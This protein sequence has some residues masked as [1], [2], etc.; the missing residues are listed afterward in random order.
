MKMPY[1]KFISFLHTDMTQV[2][3]IFPHVR[4]EITLLHSKFHGCWGRGKAKIQ[5]INNH[6]IDFVEPEYF[7]PH[8]LR[9]SVFTNTSCMVRIALSNSFAP[10]ICGRDFKYIIFTLLTYNSFGTHSE[11]ASDW[12]SQNLTNEKSTWIHVMVWWRQA[13]SHYLSQCWP[14]SMS[15]YGIAKPQYV[16]AF[17]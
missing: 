9:V 5:G 16:K 11:T 4:Q 12:M 8:T 1:L 14:R 13:I 10:A 17:I 7:G 3:E 6:D 2:F 15:P